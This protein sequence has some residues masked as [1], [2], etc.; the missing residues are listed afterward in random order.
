MTCFLVQPLT[1]PF[2][3]NFFALLFFFFLLLLILMQD[4]NIDPIAFFD[5]LAATSPSSKNGS[6]FF[7]KSDDSQANYSI[8][9]VK[10]QN[11][12]IQHAQS[13]HFQQV[14]NNLVD[15]HTAEQQGKRLLFKR[16][17]WIY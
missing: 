10:Q 4:T 1:I 14:W 5:H 16:C 13:I 15:E 9:T 2:L 7:S 11:P 12:P 3:P 8:E 6:S 17:K